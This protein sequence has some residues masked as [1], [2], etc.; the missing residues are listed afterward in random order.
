[1]KP[2]PRKVIQAVAKRDDYR[3]VYCGNPYIEFHHIIRR[4]AGGK[5][6]VDNLICLCHEHHTWAHMHREGREWCEKWREKN[7]PE[8]VARERV[9]R[10][11]A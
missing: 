4:S 3:C 5:H 7:Y 8:I 6:T 9:E 2:V 10:K 1:M 11:I